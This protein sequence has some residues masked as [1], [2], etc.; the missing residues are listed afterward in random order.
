MVLQLCCCAAP[1]LPLHAD[2][3]G[4]AAAKVTTAATLLPAPS[5]CCHATFILHLLIFAYKM[6]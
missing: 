4:D 2:A 1:A 6:L 5:A 3:D